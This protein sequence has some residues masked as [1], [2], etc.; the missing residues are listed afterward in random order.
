MS[1]HG[2]TS[3]PNRKPG[4]AIDQAKRLP[5]AVGK[6]ASARFGAKWR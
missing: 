1:I 5:A 6:P 3:F 4:A 2:N